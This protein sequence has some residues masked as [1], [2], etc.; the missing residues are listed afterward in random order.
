MNDQITPGTPA[1]HCGQLRIGQK[2]LAVNRVSMAGISHNRAVQVLRE[3][4]NH[5]S[6]LI[7]H[8]YEEEE[9][10]EE[11][12]KGFVAPIKHN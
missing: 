5:I 9:E 11:K 1:A 7:H 2:I 10:E 8:G 6:I 12:E 4:G 3:A